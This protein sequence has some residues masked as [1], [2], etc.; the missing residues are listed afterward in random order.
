MSRRRWRSTLPASMTRLYSRTSGCSERSA[1]MAPGTTTT[2]RTPRSRTRSSIP[3]CARTSAQACGTTGCALRTERS[4]SVPGRS[5]SVRSTGCSRCSCPMARF[6]GQRR[7]PV[8]ARGTTH[9]SPARHRSGTRLTV[10][11]RSGSCSGE[12]S[13]HGTARSTSSAPR[14]A[15]SPAR[16]ASP[17][18]RSGRWTGTTQCCAVWCAARTPRSASQTSGTVSSCPVAAFVA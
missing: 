9:S 12:T 6:S 5:L 7:P 3:M 4:P 13:L 15:T 14:S 16:P 1:A 11:S 8:S 18:S 2:C 10:P 17:T